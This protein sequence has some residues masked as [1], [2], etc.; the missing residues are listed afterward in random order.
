MIARLCISFVS[1]LAAG[2][3]AG[4]ISRNRSTW[5]LITGIVLLAIFVP[6]HLSIW[7]HF[8]IW[9]HLTFLISLPA[10]SIIGGRLARV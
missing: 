1:T 7:N 9:Y 8:P 3:V 6:I 2:A 5:P 10:L 4:W